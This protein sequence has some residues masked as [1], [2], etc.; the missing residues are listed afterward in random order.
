[1]ITV[2]ARLF[3]ADVNVLVYAL[4]ELLYFL[5]FVSRRLDHMLVS[6]LICVTVLYKRVCA[7]CKIVGIRN[8]ACNDNFFNPLQANLISSSPLGFDHCYT[9][10]RSCD[11][12]WPI[13]NL[14]SSVT[15]TVEYYC[16]TLFLAP[17]VYVFTMAAL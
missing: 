4:H 14:Q 5:Y 10:I 13:L 15:V 11:V 16:E 2:F 8:S 7:F 12:A 1:M 3:G 6:Y 17:T 9:A